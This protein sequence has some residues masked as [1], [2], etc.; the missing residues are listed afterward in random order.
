[1]PFSLPVLRTG[2]FLRCKFFHVICSKPWNRLLSH[3]R[4]ADSLVRFQRKINKFLI[5]HRL[6]NIPLAVDT[7]NE[8]RPQFW[9][10]WSV[11][12]A[13]TSCS[14]LNHRSQTSNFKLLLLLGSAHHGLNCHHHHPF[15]TS[16]VPYKEVKW[17]GHLLYRSPSHSFS[18]TSPGYLFF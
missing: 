9:D 14:R 10:L 13:Y 17:F 12:I 5:V 7:T 6:R 11:S 18:M 4:C 3:V 2:S 8:K 15:V 1:M 16:N